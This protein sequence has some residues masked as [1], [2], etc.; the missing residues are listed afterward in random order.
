MT[1]HL[2]SYSLGQSTA[3]VIATSER[4]LQDAAAIAVGGL[5]AARTYARDWYQAHP[6]NAWND[7]V[8]HSAVRVSQMVDRL[9]D[10]VAEAAAAIMRDGRAYYLQPS[11]G[12]FSMLVVASL[13]ADA[14]AGA[15]GYLPF[16]RLRDQVDA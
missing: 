10:E 4:V 8:R 6:T 2:A 7:A 11:D 3:A 1:Y 12:G 16:R 9:A 14:S 5:P 15:T 13:I